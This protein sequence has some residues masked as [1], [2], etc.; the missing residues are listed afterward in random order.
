MKFEYVGRSSGLHTYSKAHQHKYWELVYNLKGQGMTELNGVQYTF[1]EGT[2]LLYPPEVSHAKTSECGFEDIFIHFSGGDFVPKV[3]MLEDDCDHRFLQLLN[4]LHS[5]YYDNNLPSVCDSLFD[6]LIGLLT[7]VLDNPR[8]SYYVQQLRSTIIQEFSNP[9]FQIRMAM[10]NLPVNIDYLRR[11]FKQSV[12]LTPQGY[13]TQL[14]MESAKH[15]LADA[16]GSNLEISDV[17][18][19]V[20]YY[21]PLYFSRV[22]RKYT[23]IAPSKW[24]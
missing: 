20:G 7:P 16:G 17:A 1:G 8:E 18:Y 13:L 24:K 19:R 11:Q 22:F 12:G 10:S 3:Y 21:D 2:V 9:D 6:A 15:L 4:V 23:G 14:R 5:T